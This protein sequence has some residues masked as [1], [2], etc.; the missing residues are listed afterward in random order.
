M[1]TCSRTPPRKGKRG[2][3]LTSTKSLVTP[4]FLERQWRCSRAAKTRPA[5]ARGLTRPIA[6]MHV[7]L[8]TVSGRWTESGDEASSHHHITRPGFGFSR[9]AGT[10]QESN[11]DKKMVSRQSKHWCDWGKRT[12]GMVSGLLYW[13]GMDATNE[14]MNE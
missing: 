2:R 7:C 13:N 1:A 6:C 14:R 5:P 11:C 4:L 10:K 3:D 12:G 9:S 8:S